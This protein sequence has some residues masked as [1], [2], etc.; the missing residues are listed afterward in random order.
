MLGYSSG[1]DA[2][3]LQA[4]AQGGNEA[5]GWLSVESGVLQ[6]GEAEAQGRHYGSLQLPERRLW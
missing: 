6:A 1:A 4:E 3:E 5:C 2:R